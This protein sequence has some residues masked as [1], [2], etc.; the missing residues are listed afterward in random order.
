MSCGIFLHSFQSTACQGV[1]P[2]LYIYIYRYIYIYI[3]TN[4]IL[5]FVCVLVC[6]CAHVCV[7]VCTRVL[8]V[9]THVCL[10]THV[11]V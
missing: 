6:A 10:Y 7:G 8:C 2:V 5:Q 11:F 4:N 9:P 3:Y 1:L